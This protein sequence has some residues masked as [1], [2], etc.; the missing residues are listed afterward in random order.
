MNSFWQQPKSENSCRRILEYE[1]PRKK[2][3][4]TPVFELQTITQAGSIGLEPN[5]R[6]SRQE[7]LYPE[8]IPIGEPP[9]V[10]LGWFSRALTEGK[11]GH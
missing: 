11:A 4:A 6:D 3:V 10:K 2:K 9:E 1:S 8:G 7:L 5:K